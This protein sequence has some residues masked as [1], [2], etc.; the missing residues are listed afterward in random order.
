MGRK[1]RGN[2]ANGENT[3]IG[4]GTV[5]KGDIVSDSAV[6]RVDGQVDGHIDTKGDLVIA[7][8]GIVNG[9]VKASNLNL[10]GKIVGDV[11]VN[12]KIELEAKGRLLGNISTKLLAMD[13]T[14][15]IQGNVN[16]T[17]EDGGSNKSNVSESKQ[18]ETAQEPKESDDSTES[19][20]DEK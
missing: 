9:D 12:N 15:V 5:I 3:V 14:A 16:M 6:I 11:E 8:T 2:V 7:T 4:A 13:E 20:E 19:E 18:E 10:A 17:S 1:N